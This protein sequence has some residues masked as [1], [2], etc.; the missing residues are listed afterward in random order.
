MDIEKKETTAKQVVEDLDKTV[1]NL[2]AKHHALAGTVSGDITPEQQDKLNSLIGD[3]VELI[4]EQITQN[5]S[6]N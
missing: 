5:L 2:F 6:N 4:M 3:L 1:A